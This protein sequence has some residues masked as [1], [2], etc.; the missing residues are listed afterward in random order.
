[1]PA[2][3]NLLLEKKACLLTFLDKQS[4]TVQPPATWVL[5]SDYFMQQSHRLCLDWTE[6][7]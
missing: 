7:G 5:E 2:I 3:K 4:S 1:M 6:Q